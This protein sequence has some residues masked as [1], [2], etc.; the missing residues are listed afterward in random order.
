MILNRIFLKWYQTITF[1]LLL[2]TFIYCILISFKINTRK[3]KTYFTSLSSQTYK[4]NPFLYANETRN[5]FSVSIDNVQYPKRVALYEN[6][7]INFECLNKQISSKLPTILMWNAFKGAPNLI[8]YPFGKR[9]SFEL[10]NCPVTN[11]ELTKDRNKFSQSDMVL[12]HM[13]NLIKVMLP[14]RRDFRQRFVHVIFESPVHCHLCTSTNIINNDL[15]NFTVGYHKNSP[16]MSQYWS[17]SG[18]RWALNSDYT[19]RNIA[20][21]KRNVRNG[22]FAVALLSNC[23]GESRWRLEYIQEM[24]RYVNVTVY[25]ECGEKL[26]V[27]NEWYFSA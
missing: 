2:S 18:L 11:C 15:F 19:N 8:S 21:E 26:L 27:S 9:H 20:D 23:G 3:N 7:T 13:R 25:G 14:K 17:D 4:C 24:K 6:E 5:Q 10:L 22:G 12:F 1:I 16:Y